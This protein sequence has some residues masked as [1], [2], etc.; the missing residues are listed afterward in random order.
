MCVC[1]CVC[2]R[3]KY[4]CNRETLDFLSTSNYGLS[5]YELEAHI[6]SLV[7]IKFLTLQPIEGGGGLAVDD[8]CFPTSFKS[9]SKHN[10]VRFITHT[11]EASQK[12]QTR[13]SHYYVP[14]TRLTLESN[15]LLCEVPLR[16]TPRVMKLITTHI[17]TKFKTDR[18][19]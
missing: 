6:F 8:S 12:S 10:F 5:L 13:H 14:A 18:A 16:L 9:I 4:I 15:N 7:L 17:H 1:V 19:V 3:I 11:H 2:V